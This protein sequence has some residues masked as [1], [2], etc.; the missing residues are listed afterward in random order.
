MTL[1]EMYQALTELAN[2]EYKISL[3]LQELQGEVEALW[4]KCHTMRKE[5]ENHD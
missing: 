5:I 1:I 2:D 3:K 4:K